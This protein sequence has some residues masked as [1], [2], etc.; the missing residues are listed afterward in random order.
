MHIYSSNKVNFFL[1]SFKYELIHSES[2]LFLVDNL[3]VL[4]NK[5]DGSTIYLLFF[6]NYIGDWGGLELE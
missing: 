5:F 2:L 1:L 6:N 4:V 3:Q